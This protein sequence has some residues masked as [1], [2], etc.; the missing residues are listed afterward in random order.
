M[1]FTICIPCFNKSEHNYYI[2]T[3]SKSKCS[4]CDKDPIQGLLVT[5]LIENICE[6][7][8]GCDHVELCWKCGIHPKVCI[9]RRIT[10]T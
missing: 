5:Q 2:H 8:D 7:P 3:W 4:I 10:D 9:K 6:D 1:S